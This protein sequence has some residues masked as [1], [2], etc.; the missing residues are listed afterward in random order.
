MT[1]VVRIHEFGG[2]DVLSI[3]DDDIGAPG[4]GEVLLDQK[5]MALH[6]ADT[7]LR[8]GKY[9]L[10]PELPAVVGLDGAG[11][12]EA[13]GDGVTDFKP[14]DTA[15]YMFNLG[16]YAEKRVIAADA[17]MPVPDGIDPKNLAG[18][19]LR[20]MTAQYLLRQTYRVQSGDTVLVHTAAGGMGSL[21]CQWAKALGATVIGT[22]GSDDKKA[23]A[24]ASGAA[25]V[26]NSRTEDIAAAVND[27]TGG[28]GVAAVYDG[29]GKD[30]WDANVAALR[31]TGYLVNYGHM[32]GLLDPIDPMQLNSK[33][34][35][36][37][38]VSLPHF[39]RTPEAKRAM[40][41]DVFAAIADGILDISVSREYA[42]DDIVQAQEDL[43]ARKTTGSV[44]IVP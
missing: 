29:I 35:F 21:L 28:E 22:V 15:C 3:E 40:A 4:P 33:S 5:G 32:S 42:L 37:A 44:I 6:Y 9:F 41:E 26:V 36:F 27:I 34:L 30:V 19:F 39:M 1:K 18:T 43:V 24:T 7:M 2:S 13:V 11:V 25:H 38:K 31:P 17:L 20:G 16:A 14:G 12:V 23:V 8:E 10:K